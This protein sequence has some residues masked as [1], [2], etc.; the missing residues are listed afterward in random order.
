[1]CRVRRVSTPVRKFADRLHRFG[2]RRFATKEIP[3]N[4]PIVDQFR[5]YKDP[6]YYTLLQGIA[7]T[8]ARGYKETFDIFLVAKE[9]KWSVFDLFLALM[10]GNFIM[11]RLSY[12]PWM[13][14]H[15]TYNPYR[16]REGRGYTFF[17]SFFA[18]EGKWHLLMNATLM[19]FTIFYMRSVCNLNYLFLVFCAGG[20]AGN[21]V[22][23]IRKNK[24]Y[25]PRLGSSSGVCAMMMTMC[26]FMP[27][28]TFAVYLPILRGYQ[29]NYLWRIML[30]FT[31]VDAGCFYLKE[32]RIGHDAHLA[33]YAMG[34][35][36]GLLL[37]KFHLGVPL[38]HLWRKPVYAVPPKPP[39]WDTNHWAKVHAMGRSNIM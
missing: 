39:L 26:V 25:N 10:I 4:D 24:Q 27:W 22:P 37:K 12:E 5:A 30:L 32:S 15:F 31:G 6:K 36:G 35:F 33:G 13:R 17:T 16:W 9:K 28:R 14:K 3:K 38:T 23:H 20:A 7:Q 19:V 2:V 8:S 11:W 34:F 29:R 18:H 1:M 21:I